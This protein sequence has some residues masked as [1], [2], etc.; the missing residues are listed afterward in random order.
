MDAIGGGVRDAS[1][2]AVNPYRFRWIPG[3]RVLAFNSYQVFQGPGLNLLNDLNLV[4]ADAQNITNLFLSGWGGEFFISPDGDQIA[5]SQPD[6]IILSNADGSEY[7]TVLTYNPVLT[8]SEYRYYAMPVWSQDSRTILVALPPPDPLGQPIQSTEIWRIPTDDAPPM[9]LG[10]VYAVPHMEQ[11]ISF[12]PDMERIA[13]LRETGQPAEN[14]R[15]L[16]LA[17][18]DGS[19]DWVY[20]KAAPI[21]FLGWSPDSS[22]FAYSLGEN[23]ET[24][25]GSL[26]DPPQPLGQAFDGAQNLRWVSINEFIFWQLADNAF[27]LHAVDLNGGA[28]LLDTAFGSPP[29]F[30]YAQP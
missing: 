1:A 26:A 4:D 2:V 21:N 18:S 5:I 3:G 7:R 11:E 29:A 17:A 27:E 10:S 9:I 8:Y 24:W 23:T 14:M 30:S 22:H 20:A 12:S 6:K 15:E 25:I 28:I 16:H 13:Y 19:G